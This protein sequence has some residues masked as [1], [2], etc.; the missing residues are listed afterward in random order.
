[1][2]PSK[3]KTPAAVRAA[4]IA[5]GGVLVAAVL[6]GCFTIIVPIITDYLNRTG[7]IHISDVSYSPPPGKPAIDI[8]VQNQTNVMQTAVGLDLTFSQGITLLNLI[9]KSTY[10]LSDEMII[11]AKSGT[12]KGQVRSD[13]GIGHPFEGWLQIRPG[14]RTLTLSVP[15]REKFEKQEARS[16]LIVIPPTINLVGD[17]RGIWSIDDK[18]LTGGKIKKFQVLEFLEKRGQVKVEISVRRG[19]GKVGRYE[20]AISF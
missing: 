13:G 20:G 15:V 11:D 2:S 6:A 3:S 16:I 4:K 5:L 12:V 19:D 14:A 9:A 10:R 17:S 8:V 7:D 1:V 18:Y